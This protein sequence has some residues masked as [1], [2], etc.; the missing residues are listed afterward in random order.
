MTSR[1]TFENGRDYPSRRDQLFFFS[2][3]IFKIE[4]FQSRLRRVE[5]FVEIVKTHRDCRDCWD[6]SRRSRYLSRCS[7]DLSRNLDKK[8]QKSICR[9]L[10]KM[11]LLDR[12][13]GLDRDFSDFSDVSRQNQD[14]LIS[15][16]ISRSSR[17]TF[18]NRRD[19]PSRRDWLFFGVEIESLDRDHVETNRDPQAYIFL[20]SQ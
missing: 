11:S 8:I 14:F 17:L 1:R 5:I 3:E 12:F 10:P 7:R 13:L 20:F 2:V 15:I 16:E 18:E 9:D 6:L 4:T 19:Y